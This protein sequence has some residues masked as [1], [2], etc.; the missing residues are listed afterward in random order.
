MDEQFLTK[1]LDIQELRNA[2]EK[3]SQ[4]IRLIRRNVNLSRGLDER[5]GFEGVIGNSPAMHKV[6]EQ[7]KNLAPTDTTVLILGESGL[8]FQDSRYG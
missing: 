4:R 2:V 8:E 5:F 3:A 7:L 6:I 1:P